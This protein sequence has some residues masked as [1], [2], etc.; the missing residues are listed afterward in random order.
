MAITKLRTSN[1]ISSS[2]SKFPHD[3][4]YPAIF[5][6]SSSE[7]SNYIDFKYVFKLY[8]EDGLIHTFETSQNTNGYG[9]YDINQ[10]ISDILNNEY[11]NSLGTFKMMQEYRVSVQEY[12]ISAL[13]GTPT[14]FDKCQMSERK[15]NYNGSVYPFTWQD[16][17]N[18]ILSDGLNLT[19]RQNKETT[20]M[21]NMQS[22]HPNP[23]A[24]YYV[25]EVLF[26][27]G[28]KWQFT[29]ELAGDYEFSASDTSIDNADDSGNFIAAGYK[30]LLTTAITKVGYWDASDVWHASTGAATGIT[31]VSNA[32]TPT[33]L[34]LY[35]PYD[36][37][38]KIHWKLTDCDNKLITLHWLNAYGGFEFFNFNKYRT[39]ILSINK[40]I[41]KSKEVD[42]LLFSDNSKANKR[43]LQKDVSFNFIVNSNFL[44]NDEMVYLKSLWI[45]EKIYADIDG[46]QIPV[47]IEDTSKEVYKEDKKLFAYKI[48]LLYAVN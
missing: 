1:S 4:I 41:Y 48:N 15:D 34:W 18:K 7:S 40:D 33:E 25:Y 14:F 17:T 21:I 31:N 28:I 38:S 45:S 22:T 39:D 42:S 19:L 6:C 9:V 8:T 27:N 36:N 32:T 24:D 43:I 26:E 35:S 23:N 44:T 5:I 16:L 29:K 13:Q 30:D 10:I 46:V 3:R 12:Y 37:S 2:V 11:S 47:I 20:A